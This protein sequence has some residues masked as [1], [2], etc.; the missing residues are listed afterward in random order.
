MKKLLC[1]SY[2][3]YNLLTERDARDE[4]SVMVILGTKTYR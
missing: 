3:C 1:R 4:S 2:I